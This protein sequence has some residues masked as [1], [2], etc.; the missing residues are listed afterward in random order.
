MEGSGYHGGEGGEGFH[1][2]DRDVCAG[3]RWQ[4]D[5]AERAGESRGIENLECIPHQRVG[6]HER[7]I[8]VAAGRERARH[9]QEIV[10]DARIQVHFQDRAGILRE[11][12]GYVQHGG[13]QKLGGVEQRLVILIDVIG[14][15]LGLVAVEQ[16]QTL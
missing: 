13:T 16:D 15:K 5:V 9:G 6:S 3:Q 4:I 2:G 7:D 10:A 12:A 14:I 1:G 11:I 8:E